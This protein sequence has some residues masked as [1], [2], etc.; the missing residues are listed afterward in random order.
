MWL[1]LAADQ[2]TSRR[3]PAS[4]RSSG[5]GGQPQRSCIIA[6]C[7]EDNLQAEARK[8]KTINVDKKYSEAIQKRIDGLSPCSRAWDPAS[9][10]V[11]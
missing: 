2:G 6:P 9:L 4:C 8:P 3:G 11:S 1:I 10:S 7:E 5:G